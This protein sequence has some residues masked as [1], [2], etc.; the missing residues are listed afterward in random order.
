MMHVLIIVIVD[1]I[2]TKSSGDEMDRWIRFFFSIFVI[3]NLIV[4]FNFFF[5]RN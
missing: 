4:P 2:I 1:R 5:W 3:M